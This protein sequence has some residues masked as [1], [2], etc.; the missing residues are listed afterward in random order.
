MTAENTLVKGTPDFQSFEEFWPFYLSEHRSAASRGLHYVGTSLGWLVFAAIIVTGEW[1]FF[2][3]TFVAAYGF[4]WVGH[5]GI[6]KNKPASFRHPLWSFRGDHKML[7]CF[8][9]GK[10]D[11]ELAKLRA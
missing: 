2:P 5:F 7:V 11:A 1:M 8:L 4:A 3:L 9:T 10:I 6:E